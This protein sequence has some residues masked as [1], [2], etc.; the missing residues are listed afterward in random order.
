M[1]KYHCIEKYN[2]KQDDNLLEVNEW[3]DKFI[4]KPK[5]ISINFNAK[6]P[7]IIDIFYEE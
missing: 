6:H 7:N 1:I 3:Y 4:D 5:I 2:L